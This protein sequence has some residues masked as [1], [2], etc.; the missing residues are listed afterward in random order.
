MPC[1]RIPGRLSQVHVLSSSAGCLNATDTTHAGVRSSGSASTHRSSPPIRPIPPF[2]A[3]RE[4]SWRIT[5]ISCNP[6]I[7]VA[8]SFGLV[9]CASPQRRKVWSCSMA[10]RPGTFYILSGVLLLEPTVQYVLELPP[11]PRLPKLKDVEMSTQHRQKSTEGSRRRL[12]GATMYI[13]E[14][15]HSIS[16]CRH[17]VERTMIRIGHAIAGTRNQVC[18]ARYPPRYIV[19]VR[20]GCRRLGADCYHPGDA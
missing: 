15:S 12:F 18:E 8:V 1:M 16:R 19:Q 17:L 5:C 6:G 11:V 2:V 13:P 4:S 14:T 9:A 3:N 10:A 7:D 20:R